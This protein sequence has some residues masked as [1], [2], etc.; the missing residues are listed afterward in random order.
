MGDERLSWPGLAS[1][2]IILFG[3]LAILLTVALAHWWAAL[4]V[5]QQQNSLAGELERSFASMLDRIEIQ[6]ARALPLLGR[7]C[8]D[9]LPRLIEAGGKIP[10]LRAVVLVKH[11]RLYCSSAIGEVNKPV[12]MY[13]K[14][15]A[16]ALQVALL[17]ETPYRP[18]VPVLV[19]FCR[20]GDGEGLLYVIDLVYIADLLLKARST[21]NGRS[22]LAVDG[23]GSVDDRNVLHA[24][25]AKLPAGGTTVHSLR[26]PLAV[27]AAANRDRALATAAAY[28]LVALCLMAGVLALAYVSRGLAT[29]RKLLRAAAKGLIRNEFQLVYQPVIDIASRQCVGVEALLRW[30]HPYWGR[31]GPA[32]FMEVIETSSLIGPVSLFVLRTALAELAALS[33]P[34]TWHVAVNVA[35]RHVHEKDFAETICAALD[36]APAAPRVVLEIIERGLLH[37]GENVRRAFSVL[38][39]HG[40]KFAIDDFGTE[41]SNV[42]LLRRLRFDV[43]KIDRQF[44]SS[45]AQEDISLVKGIAA[46][47]R[48]LGMKVIAEGV[49]TNQQHE[50]LIRAGVDMAQGYLYHR[51]MSSAEL[52]EFL[53]PAS[54]IKGL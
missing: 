41:H 23:Y 37:T 38:R 25:T 30:N 51:P 16:R 35:P 14:P 13:L 3:G 45:S 39:A 28:D 44:I 33:V 5:Q 10:Y 22:V 1:A 6:G 11:G 49:E 29:K 46:F 24:G 31:Q 20:T 9:V 52:N 36:A 15:S 34:A 42:D 50:A 27:T 48:V 19:V 18:S 47:A 7:P 43:L 2:R 17:S 40:V 32:A 26:W 54:P 12:G 21:G 4:R 8:Q 53:H